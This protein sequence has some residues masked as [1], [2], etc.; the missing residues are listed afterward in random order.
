MQ[1]FEGGEPALWKGRAERAR[2]EN[3]HDMALAIRLALPQERS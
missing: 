1:R 3:S 2:A